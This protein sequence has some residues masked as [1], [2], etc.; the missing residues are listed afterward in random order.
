M[1]YRLAAAMLSAL[2]LLGTAP[3]VLHAQRDQLGPP[4]DHRTAFGPFY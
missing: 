4:G 3:G 1:K 2:F